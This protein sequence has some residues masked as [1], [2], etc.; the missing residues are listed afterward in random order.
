MIFSLIGALLTGGLSL[1]GDVIKGKN[2]EK[3]LKLENDQ[4]RIKNQGFVER[5][6]AE[7]KAKA[8]T[9]RMEGDIAWENIMATGS[10]TSWKDEYMTVFVTCPYWLAM[11]PA[12]F[13]NMLGVYHLNP[14]ECFEATQASINVIKSFPEAL[15][16]GV[17]AALAAS[18]GIRGAKDFF[19]FKKGVK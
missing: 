2:E 17:G 12:V 3:R 9:T 4:N 6:A 16:Y 5:A 8:M 11:I 7:A 14:A 13:G 19:S 15:H 1:A 10:L 18:Y